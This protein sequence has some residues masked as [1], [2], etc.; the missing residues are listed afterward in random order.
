MQYAEVSSDS[1]EEGFFAFASASAASSVNTA[2]AAQFSTRDADSRPSCNASSTYHPTRTLQADPA[3]S[4]GCQAAHNGNGIDS[5]GCSSSR[6]TGSCGGA[7]DPGST[8]GGGD[9]ILPCGS[10]RAIPGSDGI[11]GSDSTEDH[12]DCRDAWNA[13]SAAVSGRRGDAPTE[14]AAPLTGRAAELKSA[15]TACLA[16]GKA[17]FLPCAGLFVVV[18]VYARSKPPA[19]QHNVFYTQD[20]HPV[21]FCKGQC[22]LAVF[23]AC[24]NRR[25]KEHVAFDENAL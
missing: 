6:R 23:A 11:P 17:R 7:Y 10:I 22:H 1:D 4:G 12:L 20:L 16:A 14:G 5:S 13:S 21:R 15:G 2:G 3:S 25:P 8:G 9:Q 18:F 24:P 19:H